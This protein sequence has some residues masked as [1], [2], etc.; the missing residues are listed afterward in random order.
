[1]S[2]PDLAI[3]PAPDAPRAETS[4]DSKSRVRRETI[5]QLV[6]S[7][8]FLIGLGVVLFWIVC[9]LF[10]DAIVPHDPVN[11]SLGLGTSA[12]PSSKYWFGL[13]EQGRDVFSR[14]LAG[15]ANILKVAPLAT[16]EGAP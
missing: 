14:V 7:P 5:K 13:D 16:P 6:K 4:L 2:T 10:S 8:S 12:A 11:D 3:V 9:A 15:S 1:M